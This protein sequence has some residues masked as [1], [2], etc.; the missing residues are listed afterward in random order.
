MNTVRVYSE[1]LGKDIDVEVT[2]SEATI[3]ACQETGAGTRMLVAA[4]PPTTEETAS[5]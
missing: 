1:K 3:H 5:E 4:E 2:P